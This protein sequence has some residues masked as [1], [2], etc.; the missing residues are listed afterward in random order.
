MLQ[1]A[2][3]RGVILVYVGRVDHPEQR[4]RQR[5]VFERFDRHGP[6]EQRD[7]GTRSRELVLHRDAAGHATVAVRVMPE[8]A[9]RAEHPHA[10]TRRNG[11]LPCVDVRTVGSGL[12]PGVTHLK[13]QPV[14][15]VADMGAARVGLGPVR[16]IGDEIVDSL[17]GLAE[18][19]LRAG[20]HDAQW[21]SPFCSSLEPGNSACMCTRVAS[22][23][24]NPLMG[25]DSGGGSG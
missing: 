25:K 17:G 18:R 21:W 13:R 3:H 19:R 9:H 14:G 15:Q 8:I 7:L 20:G 10:W 1:L 16:R 5:C 22:K 2:C 12:G 6:T 24:R 23:L 4:V 11:Q